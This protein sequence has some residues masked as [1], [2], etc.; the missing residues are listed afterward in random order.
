MLLQ[1]CLLSPPQHFWWKYGKIVT[2]L[3]HFPNLILEP[4]YVVIQRCSII[5]SK[6]KFKMSKWKS[7]LFSFFIFL[8]QLKDVRLIIYLNYNY[9]HLKEVWKI[10]ISLIFWHKVFVPYRLWGIEMQCVQWIKLLFNNILIVKLME[11][12]P[13]KKK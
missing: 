4:F 1:I 8:L 12:L 11:H 3:L 7:V 10:N 5:L 9:C 6:S 2:L 13:E